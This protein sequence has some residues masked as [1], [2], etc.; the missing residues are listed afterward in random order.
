MPLGREAGV[1]V[2]QGSAAGGRGVSEEASPGKRGLM[3]VVCV[4]RLLP[5]LP[6]V[7]SSVHLET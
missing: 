6:G 5:S 7:L 4:V 2:D 1:I 3:M